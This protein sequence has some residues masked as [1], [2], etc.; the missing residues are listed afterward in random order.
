MRRCWAPAGN[1]L[2]SVGNTVLA[3]EYFT[4][5]GE[6]LPAEGLYRLVDLRGVQG[7]EALTADADAGLLLTPRPMNGVFQ[8]QVRVPTSW[9][10]VG[11]LYLAHSIAGRTVY[12]TCL[13]GSPLAQG[14]SCDGRVDFNDG[15]TGRRANDWLQEGQTLYALGDGG[16]LRF[17]SGATS[18]ELLLPHALD[19]TQ[20]GADEAGLATLDSS[21]TLRVFDV[22][23]GSF[24]AQL[25]RDAG[26]GG[27]W[28]RAGGTFFSRDSKD[29]VGEICEVRAS[30]EANCS[31]GFISAVSGD[32]AWGLST[33]FVDG[34]IWDHYR[35]AGGWRGGTAPFISPSGWFPVGSVSRAVSEG[36]IVQ[37]PDQ[38]RVLVWTANATRGYELF[39]FD[40][41]SSVVGSGLNHAVF[42]ASWDGGTFLGSV[43]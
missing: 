29:A 37:S 5:G 28:R 34:F 11:R 24:S 25:D 26:V 38:R 21:N 14:F 9:Q 7:P 31:P 17:A 2:E 15:G 42:W 33:I 3:R 8:I 27:L 40:A 20:W 1:V 10:A 12:R 23:G 30:T 39:L 41:P 13:V 19:V 35:F 4:D 36:V 6:C 43:Y 18:A 16:V 22:D 32:D